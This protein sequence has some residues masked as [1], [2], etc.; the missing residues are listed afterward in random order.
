[1][2][3]A[4]GKFGWECAARTYFNQDVTRGLDPRVH[5]SSKKL[6]AT[7]MDGRIK[8]GHDT[9]IAYRT[10]SSERR[11][12]GKIAAASS[13]RGHG[14]RTIL[15]TRTARATRALPT[16]RAPPTGRRRASAN[17]PSAPAPPPDT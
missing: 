9:R 17:P 6:L 2:F 3:L 13:P 14:A 5:R 7:R 1:M 10:I 16:L 15:P 8:P 4:K 12:V 11:R